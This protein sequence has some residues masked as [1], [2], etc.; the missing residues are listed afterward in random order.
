MLRTGAGSL[1]GPSVV[2]GAIADIVIG[3][4]IAFRRS[5]RVGLYGAVGLS[6]FYAIAGT[7]LLPEL[8]SEPLGPLM[9][10]WPI[11]VLHLAALAIIEER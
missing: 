8:W 5:S 1:A 7:I 10:I 4:A 3:V 11:I 9:K 2:A 6:L